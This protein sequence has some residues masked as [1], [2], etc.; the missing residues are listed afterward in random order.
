MTDLQRMQ[1]GLQYLLELDGEIF[2]L[3]NG[4]WIFIQSRLVKPATTTP[5]G[6]KY[7]LTLHDRM[8]RRLLGYD[9][10]HAIKVGGR[11]V[12]TTRRTWDHRH[13]RNR[14]EPYEFKDVYQLLDDFLREA[15]R[16]IDESMRRSV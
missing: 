5:H 14:V 11:G 2:P 9:N 6:I 3:E 4:F 13:R 16:I 12:Q 8:N 15:S 10:A 1:Q 7:A